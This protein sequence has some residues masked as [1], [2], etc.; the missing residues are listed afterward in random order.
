MKG[1]YIFTVSQDNVVEEQSNPYA[2]ISLKLGDENGNI[3][4]EIIRDD[5]DVCTGFKYDLF[6]ERKELQGN[7]YIFIRADCGKNINHSLA[8][9]CYGPNK[10]EFKEANKETAKN[11]GDKGTFL[12]TIPEGRAIEIGRVAVNYRNNEDFCFIPFENYSAEG[13]RKSVVD[14]INLSPGLTFSKLI[15]G[16]MANGEIR[17]KENTLKSSKSMF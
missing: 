7:F 9:S 1:E 8:L 3:I 15:T 17:K 6:L 13:Q 4:D 14:R 10:V 16:K 11:L 2:R 12:T 5:R